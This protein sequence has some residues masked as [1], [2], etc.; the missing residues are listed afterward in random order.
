MGVITP[1]LGTDPK[2]WAY[3]LGNFSG[4]ALS[5]IAQRA[6]YGETMAFRGVGGH[7][8]AFNGYQLIATVNYR[9]LKTFPLALLLPLSLL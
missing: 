1:S 9:F 3:C 6:L 5:E 7:D 4:R 2:L 8:V